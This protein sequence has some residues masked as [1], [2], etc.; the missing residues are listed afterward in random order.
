MVG[1]HSGRL[2]HK[3]GSIMAYVGKALLKAIETTDLAERIDAL[4]QS[5]KNSH[6]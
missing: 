2:E 3:I 5:S 6:K 4:E 1:L